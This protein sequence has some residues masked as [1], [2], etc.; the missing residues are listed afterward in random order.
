MTRSWV[1]R[2]TVLPAA[3]VATALFT[4]VSSSLAA[5]VPG[6]GG[7]KLGPSGSAFYNPP[8]RLPR[9][10]PGSLIWA[11]PIQ[12]PRGAT[13]HKVLY[14]STLRNGRPVAVSGLV[15]APKGKAPRRGRPVVAWA[16]GTLGGARDC[17]PSIPGNP[18]Q[19]LRA[20]YTYSSPYVLDVG[21]PA[22]T[23]FLK[24]GYVVTATDY[25]GLGTPG[26]HQYTVGGTEARNVLDSVRAAK[27]LRN[28]RA[29]NDV[30]LL[31]WSQGGG[32]AIFAGQ[33]GASSYAGSLRIRGI[34]ALAPAANTGPDIQ[35]L[36]PPGPVSTLSP[37]VSAVQELNAFRGFAAAYRGLDIDDVV[38]PPGLAP[39]RALG[40]QCT[41]H[42]GDVVQELEVDP[43]TFF[44][45]P[46][47]DVWKQRFDENTAGNQTTVAPVLT[48]QG[49]ADTVVNPNGTAQ[50]IQRA[51]GFEQ[52]VQLS[53]YP[54]A[55]HQTIPFVAQNEYVRW[56]ANRFAGRPAPTGCSP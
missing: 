28:T 38:A 48:M 4:G 9:G 53:T 47:P 18:A 31:G 39:L 51:C 52:P 16:H 6:T 19:N 1:V 24:A 30:A 43:E 29:G 35:G 49:T 7:V 5:S 17:A 44:K 55:N 2:R 46:I 32:A 23:R 33:Q 3:I 25:Q 15:I 27:Q 10:N 54:G 13:A 56:I 21:V 41:I 11:R 26:V 42:L 40:V 45:R 14:R 50:Y 37:S 22:L 12:A 8:E 34:A 20:Y 36:V